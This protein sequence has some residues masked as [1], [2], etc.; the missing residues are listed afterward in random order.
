MIVLLLNDHI[1]KHAW[2]GFVTAKLSDLAGLVVAPPL[3][4]LLLLRRADLAAT[5]LTGALFTVVKTT[6]TG[7]EAASQIWTTLA[8]SSRVLAD[9][10][11]LLALPALLLAWWVRQRSRRAVA[12][13]WRVLTAVPL[14]VLA[15]T[16]TAGHPG[17]PGAEVV[18]L[19]D[20]VL[21][22]DSRYASHDGGATWETYVAS[23][24]YAGPEREYQP[25]QR[26]ACL[27]EHCYRLVRHHV[28]VL[29][30]GDGGRTWEPEWEIPPGRVTM[31]ERELVGGR[32]DEDPIVSRT[33]VVQDRPGGHV[34]VVAN[35]RDGVAVRG[36]DG[37]WRRFGFS[38]DGRLLESAA[39]P[40]DRPADDDAE[41]L[42]AGLAAAWAT[43]LG[44][45]VQSVRARRARPWLVVVLGGLGALL[46]APLP[47]E[48]V[49][50]PHQ[51]V[52]TD[53]SPLPPLLAALGAALL[54]CVVVV[55]CSL[56]SDGGVGS[57]GAVDALALGVAVGLCVAGPFKA[58]STGWIDHG[59]A[60]AV[61]VVA[62]PLVC[63]LGALALRPRRYLTGSSTSSPT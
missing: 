50:G 6:E 19:R 2:P 25:G 10:G 51:N 54:I 38:A 56:V 45:A 3:V 33:L 7:A 21:V 5:I 18:D 48:R 15:V 20:G 23:D 52:M 29:R 39:I 41:M 34:V 61:A 49:F 53:W 14:A 24:A 43:L 42:V 32:P 8:G 26:A 58:W 31:L 37:T 27:R 62:A 22:L 55:A 36:V 9:P 57:R 1:L 16:A 59:A 46:I 60:L 11:D 28:K 4:A 40:L 30:S 17:M 35:G 63:L 44:L 47:Y 13:R 12:A